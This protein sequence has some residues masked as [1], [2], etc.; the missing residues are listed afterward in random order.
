MAGNIIIVIILRIRCEIDFVIPLIS[1]IFICANESVDQ[2]WHDVQF[3]LG[4][5]WFM[6]EKFKT[7][8][9]GIFLSSACS[10]A[11]FAQQH[12]Y[13][14]AKTEKKENSATPKINM[15][16]EI[17]STTLTE[18]WGLS[19]SYYFLR[20]HARKLYARCGKRAHVFGKWNRDTEK[21]KKKNRKN[22]C[23]FPLGC[24]RIDPFGLG[25]FFTRGGFYLSNGICHW[26]EQIRWDMKTGATLT[27]DSANEA[28]EYEFGIGKENIRW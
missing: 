9:K 28:I 15:K 27:L 26:I 6:I 24:L 5:L 18:T 16:I 19:S 13:N 4:L 22:R 2:K 21:G 3:R 7:K 12:S 14:S 1:H 25:A 8:I 20:H 10:W 17:M 23:N 11:L